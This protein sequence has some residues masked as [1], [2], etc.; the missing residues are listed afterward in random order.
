MQI[1][2]Y[3][4]GKNEELQRYFELLVQI[5]QGGL[6]DNGFTIPQQSAANIALIKS[7]LFNPIMPPGTIW[8]NTDINKLEFITTSA[9]PAT[10]TNAVTETITSA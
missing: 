6:S 3:L 5:L 8:F 4:Y 9:I 10:S 2:Q 7:Y 1:P